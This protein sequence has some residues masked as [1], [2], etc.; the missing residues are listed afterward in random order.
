MRVRRKP[1]VRREL[2]I[3]SDAQR[4]PAGLCV[5][6]GKMV[7]GLKPMTPITSE[8][9]KG[10]AFD[11]DLA[12]RKVAALDLVGGSWLG[13]CAVFLKTALRLDAHGRQLSVELL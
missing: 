8:R 3:V 4:A 9:L 5:G 2:I 1:A 6:W 7:L 10:A 11:H 12:L 13:A